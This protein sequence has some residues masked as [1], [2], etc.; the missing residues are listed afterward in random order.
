MGIKP[1]KVWDSFKEQLDDKF[2]DYD[3][4]LEFL[5]KKKIFYFKNVLYDRYSFIKSRGHKA[6]LVQRFKKGPI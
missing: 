3:N 1:K 2:F 4:Y 5:I 6:L